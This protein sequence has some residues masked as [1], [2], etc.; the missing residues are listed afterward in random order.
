[1]LRRLD[2]HNVSDGGVLVL[3]ISLKL[4]YSK[5]QVLAQHVTPY[6]VSL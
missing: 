4:S 5:L 2:R 3:R 1:M 6:H